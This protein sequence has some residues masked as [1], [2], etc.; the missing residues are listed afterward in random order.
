[1]QAGAPSS[2]AA[3]RLRRA[4]AVLVVLV[5]VAT[6]AAVVVRA[7]SGSSLPAVDVPA[8]A[9]RGTTVER[10][11]LRSRA[12]D[13]TL[14]QTVVRPTGDV[15]GRPLLLLLHGKQQD[16]AWLAGAPLRAALA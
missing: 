9:T 7:R 13:R 12:A 11:P 15:R 4:L 1:M 5:V 3:R 8:S 16:P 6:A 10:Y 2:P 14:V